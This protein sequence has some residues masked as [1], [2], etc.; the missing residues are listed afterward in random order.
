MLWRLLDES[1]KTKTMNKTINLFPISIHQIDVNGFDE[2]KNNLINYIYNLKNSDP[3][4]LEKSNCGGWHSSLFDLNGNNVL[5][6]FLSKCLSNFS[7]LQEFCSMDGD[8]WV[9]INPPKS[10]NVKHSHSSTDLAGVLWIKCPNDSGNILF[11][12]PYIF[13]DFNSINAYTDKFKYMNKQYHSFD[14]KPVEGRMLIFPAHLLHEVKEN[15]SKEDRISVSFNLKISENK[16]Y[17]KL[18]ETSKN[19]LKREV[20]A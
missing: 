20:M 13:E 19:Y 10:F 12:N 1:N 16:E 3:T 17:K 6:K 7:A 11:E 14:F 5:Q 8:Y 4:G 9:N 2:V 15:K 18:I